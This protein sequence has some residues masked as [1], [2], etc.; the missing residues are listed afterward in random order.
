M[1]EQADLAIGAFSRKTSH[2]L[3]FHWQTRGRPAARWLLRE[4]LQ[5]LRRSKAT[6]GPQHRQTVGGGRVQVARRAS[7][8]LSYPA[9]DPRGLICSQHI[10]RLL[11]PLASSWVQPMGCQ[12]SDWRRKTTQGRR[13]ACLLQAP[14][15]S[16]AVPRPSH[17]VSLASA[18]QRHPLPHPF[19]SSEEPGAPHQAGGIP[20][21][22]SHVSSESFIKLCSNYPILSVPSASCWDPDSSREAE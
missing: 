11:G 3:C 13:W 9:L 21:P 12:G 15:L 6:L 14:A 5:V 8:N 16:A 1:I 20:T 18:L 22:R 2:S 7:W 19:P 10:T 4:V 17:T